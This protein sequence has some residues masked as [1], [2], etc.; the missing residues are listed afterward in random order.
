LSAK[1]IA[2][3]F[4]DS[5]PTLDDAGL[6]EDAVEVADFVLSPCRPSILDIGAAET[7]YNLAAPN[8]GFVLTD[9]T[10]GAKWDAMND[11][12]LKMLAGLG[13][14]VFKA[15]LTHRPSYVDSMMAGKTGPETDKGAAKEV[16]DLW[17]EVVQWMS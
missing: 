3:A 16:A 7:I 14:H 12:A 9:V 4:V 10:T 2:Y 5:P 17:Q 6:V 1:G 11:K 8:I 13:G 15:R